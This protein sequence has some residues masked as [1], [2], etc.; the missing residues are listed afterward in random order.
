MFGSGS[1]YCTGVH[2]TDDAVY[3][4]QM[5]RRRKTISLSACARVDLPDPYQLPERLAEDVDRAAL[6]AA[7]R[8]LAVAGVECQRPYFGLGGTSS[9]VKRRFLIPNSRTETREQLMWE[10]RQSLEDDYDD[11]VL[12]V[13]QTSRYGFVVAARREVLELYGVLCRQAK[14]GKPGFD[15]IP[16]ALVNAL[17]GGGAAPDEGSDL[18]VQL[19]AAQGRVVLMRDGEFEAE[20]V[21][22]WEDEGT[23]VSAAR[24]DLLR[25]YVEGLLDTGQGTEAADRVWLA[26]AQA[27]DAGEHL[28]GLGRSITPLNP[29]AQ[30]RRR[31][32][33]DEALEAMPGGGAALAVAAGLAFRGLADV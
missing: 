27:L 15:M 22:D 10:A 20:A 17:E 33:A 9:F 32:S 24:I 13:L 26:S 3:A 6:A 7:L 30:L 11:F 16:F 23:A 12:D 31:T 1:K 5:S 21:W 4:V 19:E 18:L 2:I 25:S 29:F 8:Q 28:A 14:I